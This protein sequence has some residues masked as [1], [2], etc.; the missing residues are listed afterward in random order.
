MNKGFSLIELLVVIAIVGILSAI[1]LPSYRV[2]FY[3]THINSVITTLTGIQEQMMA[4]YTATGVLPA[5]ANYKGV[6]IQ[7]QTG[8]NNTPINQDGIGAMGYERFPT[9]TPGSNLTG[10]GFYV[11]FTDPINNT[12]VCKIPTCRIYIATLINTN[13]IMRTYCGI[14]DANNSNSPY[15]DL[16][17]PSCSCTGFYGLWGG[18]MGGGA[19][20]DN[21]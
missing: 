17:P 16:L 18:N 13:N 1:A 4:Q 6:S 5:Y 14:Y 20:P 19:G 9:D 12:D 10:V 15:A 21:C 8:F 7:G 2:Y 11:I 3:K